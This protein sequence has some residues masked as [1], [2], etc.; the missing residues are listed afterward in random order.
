MSSLLEVSPTLLFL[1]GLKSLSSGDASLL[2]LKRSKASRARLGREGT[3]GERAGVGGI[4][5]GEEG[6]VV[7]MMGVVVEGGE[8]MEMGGWE[9]E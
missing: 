5:R 6:R 3:R 7:V 4:W 1:F 9:E 8:E 2:P